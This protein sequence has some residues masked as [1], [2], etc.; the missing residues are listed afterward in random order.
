MH[1]SSNMKPRIGIQFLDFKMC[2][3]SNVVVYDYEL[4]VQSSP[5]LICF[6]IKTFLY[7]FPSEINIFSSELG[8]LLISE[9]NLIDEFRRG[10]IY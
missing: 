2:R 10:D 7:V 4:E 3:L 5:A 8:R 1:S 9:R 6:V